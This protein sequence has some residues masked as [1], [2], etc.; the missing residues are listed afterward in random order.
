MSGH[1]K[2]S[3][4]KRQKG[5]EDVKRGM[6]FTKI[7]NAITVASKLGGSGSPES[8][9]R[10]RMM[11][12][13]AK[14]LN[15]PK[16]NIQRAIDRGLGKLP[17]QSIDEVLFEGFGPSK[18]AYLIEVVTDNKM[19]TLQELR[20]MFERA[21]G[22]LGDSGST[23]YMFDKRGEIKIVSKGGNIE[24]EILEL[25]DLGAEDV[26]EYEDSFDGAQ[27]KNGQKY[28][29]YTK[30][31]ELDTLGNKITQ[32]GFSVESSEIVMIPNIITE[33]NDKESAKKVV[34]FTEKLESL[35]DIQ[36]VYANFSLDD[37][38]YT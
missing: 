37:S 16:D 9:P 33:V 26:E 5:V 1:S 38:M 4:I 15:M 19:R 22:H 23:F 18:V 32:A 3:T 25:I 13:Q 2:W 35:D 31:S 14:G 17:G 28:V 24:D 21:G 36:K 34:E 20:N 29:V 6:T 8:N 11:L 27:D 7:A 10:L 12:E 30:V